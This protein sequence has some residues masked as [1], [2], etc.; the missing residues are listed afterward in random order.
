MYDPTDT[1][2]E[3]N[4]KSVEA[5]NLIV[6][7]HEAGRVTD[8]EASFAMKV[9]YTAVSGM[10]RQDINELLNEQ[11]NSIVEPPAMKRWAYTMLK[12][13]PEGDKRI[14]ISHVQGTTTVLMEGDTNRIISTATPEMA[15]KK[16][17]EVFAALVNRGWSVIQREGQW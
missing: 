1:Q 12:R 8:R 5:L 15:L 10:L 16:L 11:F 14:I 3:L 13:N 7:E 17:S 6:K 9:L 4:R 2:S